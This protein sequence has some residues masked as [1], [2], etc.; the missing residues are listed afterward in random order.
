MYHCDYC[1]KDLSTSLRIK[2]AVCP[3]FDLCLEC[4]SVGAE[5]KPHSK[6]HAYRIVD[7]LSFPVYT[8]DWGADQ[9]MLLLEAVELYGLGNWSRVSE[10][11]GRPAKNCREHYFAVY[12]ETDMFPKPKPAPEMAELNIESVIQER[13][14]VGSERIANTRPLPGLRLSKYTRAHSVTSKRGRP[15]LLTSA[16]A[17]SALAGVEEPS[18]TSHLP[19][20]QASEGSDMKADDEIYDEV[21]QFRTKHK[22]ASKPAQ[23]SDVSQHQMF[24]TPNML[25]TQPLGVSSME[26]DGPGGELENRTERAKTEK[27]ENLDH[28]KTPQVAS[29]A[30]EAATPVVL[31]ET[32]QTGYNA[33]RHEF[34]PEYDADAEHLLAE[35][36]FGENDSEEMVNKKLRLIE[37][38]NRRLDER[39]RRREFV[40]SRGLVN[41]KRQQY[42]DRRRAHSERDLLGRLRV[43]A[44]YMQQPQWEALA[45]GILT[46]HRIRARIAQLQHFRDL[47]MRT[48]DEVEEYEAVESNNRKDPHPA[49]QVG[50]PRMQRIPVDEMAM[51]TELQ[52]LGFAHALEL[53]HDQ[54]ATIPEGKGPEGLQGWRLRRG[55]LL[56]VSSLPDSVPLDGRERELCANERYLPAQYLAIKQ[57]ALKIQKEKGLCSK[58]DVL[59]LPFLVEKSRVGRLHEFFVESGWIQETTNKS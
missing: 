14:R 35:L 43:L 2:C 12:V 28:K 32:H 36:E 58:E 39:E 3:D 15:L 13:R 10:H 27:I 40:V 9:E 29:G 47:G 24:K 42:L 11:V 49:A 26:Q 21:V 4:F 52:A 18:S 46:E 59:S 5:I 23:S 6:T 41:V 25:T 54:H 30:P 1:H 17:P 53:L 37:I 48:F 19:T 31:S 8:L 22:S 16:G 7:N 57:E 55:V 45:D 44:R 50:K 56:D 20:A 38:Y 51:E 33:K 34:E